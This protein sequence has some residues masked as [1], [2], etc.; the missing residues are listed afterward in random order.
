MTPPPPHPPKRALL[1]AQLKVT[2]Q[3]TQELG[4]DR[5][6]QDVGGGPVERVKVIGIE[7]DN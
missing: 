7:Q 3:S 1:E 4:G 6:P 2:L 5:S